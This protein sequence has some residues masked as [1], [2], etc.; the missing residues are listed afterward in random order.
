MCIN[1]VLRVLE[2]HYRKLGPTQGHVIV[3]TC[4]T[5]RLG[6]DKDYNTGALVVAVQESDE[7]DV[8]L[9]RRKGK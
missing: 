6:R 3:V 7:E 2:R 9:I 8:P 1:S 4:L 5:S